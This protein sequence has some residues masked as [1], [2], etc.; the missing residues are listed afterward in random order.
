MRTNLAFLSIVFV[1]ALLI[2]CTE[3]DNIVSYGPEI[4][5]TVFVGDSLTNQHCVTLF[6]GQTIDAGTVCCTV[7]NDELCI[8]YETIDDWELVETHLWIGE[9]LSEMPRTQKGNPKIG[10]FPYHSGDITGDTTFTVCIPI[11]SLG[12]E[13]YV[14]DRTFLIAS[15]AVV[16]TDTSG[17]EYQTETGWGEGERIIPRG[18]WA[19]YFDILLVCDGGGVPGGDFETASAF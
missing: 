12:G 15:H 11:D 16:Q 7:E 19:M 1:L 13:P 17:G 18:N 8:T 5:Q 3:H 10:H 9:D 6:A 4:L 14:C 2:G